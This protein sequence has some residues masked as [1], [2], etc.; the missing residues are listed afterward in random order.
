MQTTLEN[1][2]NNGISRQT[3]CR[4]T[5]DDICI[6]GTIEGAE[7]GGTI[8]DI[9][10]RKTTKG[11]RQKVKRERDTRFLEG[12]EHLHF[13]GDIHEDWMETIGSP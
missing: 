2:A 6:G 8:D 12:E 4:A 10:T 9:S 7:A 11:T 1:S 3:N 13:D 5:T